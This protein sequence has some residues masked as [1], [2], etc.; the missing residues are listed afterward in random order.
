MALGDRRIV[1]RV[2]PNGYGPDERDEW[3]AGIPA[4]ATFST[5]VS[6]CRPG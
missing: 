5:T 1:R 4:V 3:P 2:E 6:T